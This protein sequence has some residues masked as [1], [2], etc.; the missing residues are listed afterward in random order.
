MTGPV[1]G[2]G[3]HRSRTTKARRGIWR[4][5]IRNR[6]RASRSIRAVTSL[7]RCWATYGRR[8]AQS[9]TRWTGPWS[10]C[11]IRRNTGASFVG[12]ILSVRRNVVCGMECARGVGRQD[13]VQ[14]S[15]R[16][17]FK[18]TDE[19]DHWRPLREAR[20]AYRNSMSRWRRAR[21]RLY[22]TVPSSNPAA[23]GGAAPTAKCVP[24]RR[25]DEHWHVATTD[26]RPGLRTGA[27]IY[28]FA[29]I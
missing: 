7:P 4:S 8:A 21:G 22:A 14:Q 3:I 9:P 25:G 19:S 1:V 29:V 18:S 11:W 13:H 28:R 6:S 5:T 20:R 2:N 27:V 23:Q 24:F 16:R 10:R 17:L 12:S 26:P 15:A